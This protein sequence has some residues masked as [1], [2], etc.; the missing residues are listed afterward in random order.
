MEKENK[1]NICDN[2][3]IRD[4]FSLKEEDNIK[5]DEILNNLKGRI[6]S[7]EVG[8]NVISGTGREHMAL[9]SALL[10]LGVCIRLIALTKDGIEEI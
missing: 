6:K 5:I 8:V 4:L 9:V 7:S 10:Q 1:K 3:R 2:I